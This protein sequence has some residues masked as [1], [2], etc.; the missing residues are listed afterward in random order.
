MIVKCKSCGRRVHGKKVK[1]CDDDC[2]QDFTYKM[3]LDGRNNSIKEERRCV[4]CGNVFLAKSKKHFYCS[5]ECQQLPRKRLNLA[6]PLSREY[7]LERGNFKCSDCGIENN[8]N[9]ELHHA[10]P[11][12]KGGLDVPENI[13]V[14]CIKC[15]LIRHSIL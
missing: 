2:K 9:L 13:V 8:N 6:K 10:K 12:C 3:R 11:L 14:L 7:F 5:V 15:H 1:F 4:L